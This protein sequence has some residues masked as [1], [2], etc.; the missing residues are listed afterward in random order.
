MIKGYQKG[1]FSLYMD[2]VTGLYGISDSDGNVIIPAEYATKDEIGKP[3]ELLV[4][5]EIANVPIEDRDELLVEDYGIETVR[6]CDNCGKVFHEGY[7]LAG[8]HAC[9]DECAIALYKDS[10]GNILP[11]AEELFQTDIEENDDDC[12][13]TVFEG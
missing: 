8:E 7:V 9:C 5:G 2:D 12:Y 6:V 3:Y 13:W 4:L 10:N 11:N 1:D